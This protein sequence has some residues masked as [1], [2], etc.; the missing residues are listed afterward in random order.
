MSLKK[1]MCLTLREKAL[2]IEELNNGLTVTSLSKKYGVAKSTICKIKK[3]KQ[4][5][6]NAVTDTY[7]GP[8]KRRTLKSSELPKMEKRLYH[9]FT[10]QRNKNLVVSGEMIKEKAKLLHS[11]IKESS[12]EFTAS[13]GWLQRFKRRFGIRF[14]KISGEKLSSQPELVDPFKLELKN[15]IQELNLTL[16]QLY[17]ADETGLYWKLLPDRTFVSSTEKTAPGRKT[18][19]QRITF[20]ACTN[21]TG[22]HK[23]K[24]LVIGKAKTPR[25]FK[26]FACPVDYDH[27]KSAWMTAAIF[28]NWFHMSF[29]PQVSFLM[30][31]SCIVCPF[32]F[33][34]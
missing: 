14:L 12:K 19:K 22:N 28:K 34:L 21:A 13:E 16:D 32:L 10:T 5:I 7:V 3:N 15:K 23:V 24:P 33:W 29:V 6:L 4:V 31:R 27:S 26:N 2:V 20:L 18:E 8:G 9:W 1:T 11:E 25:A 30:N 17:N